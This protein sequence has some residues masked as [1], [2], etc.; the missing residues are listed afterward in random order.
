MQ[1]SPTTI[2]KIERLNLVLVGLGAGLSWLLEY[3]HGL[4]LLLG[5]A[6]MHGNFWLLKKLVRSLLSAPLPGRAQ[7]LARSRLVYGQ[8]LVFS[9]AVERPAAALPSPRDR[10]LRLG[11][12][13]CCWPA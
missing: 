3:G 9:G 6:V 10:A 11:C 8:E 13:Y 2:E 4:S 12:L 7:P 1:T 5:G